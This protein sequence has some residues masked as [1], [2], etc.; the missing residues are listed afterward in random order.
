MSLALN[1]SA[2][3]QVGDPLEDVRHLSH[4]P[5]SLLHQGQQLLVL[6]RS[7][8]LLQERYFGGLLGWRY[9]YK[10]IFDTVDQGW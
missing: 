8:T 4:H 3:Y 7:G 9:E 10:G 5:Q 1:M 6:L 2:L